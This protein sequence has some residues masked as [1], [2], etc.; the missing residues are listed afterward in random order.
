MLLDKTTHEFDAILVINQSDFNCVGSEEGHVSGKV[1]RL[2]DNHPLDSEL[3]HG[4]STHHA[5]TKSGVQSHVVVAS[6]SPRIAKTIHL[7]VGGWVAI[8]HSSVV[9]NR[10]DVVLLNQSGA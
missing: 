9:S 8:L 6:A 10:N 4:P 2:T 5:G 3:Q 1:L 7:S